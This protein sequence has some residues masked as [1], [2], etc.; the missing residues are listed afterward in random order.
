MEKLLPFC[1]FLNFFYQSEEFPPFWKKVASLVQPAP[2]LKKSFILTFIAKFEEDNL[3]P[4]VKG[5][6]GLLKGDTEKGTET[7]E[8]IFA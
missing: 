4:F 5:V 2:L 3:F 6:G 8:I 1:L 7:K